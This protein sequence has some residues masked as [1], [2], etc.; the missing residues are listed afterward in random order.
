MRHD[1]ILLHQ[2]QQ[3]FLQL[4]IQ[5]EGRLALEV[6]PLDVVDVG[7]RHAGLAVQV[8]DTA[9]EGLRIVRDGVAGELHDLPANVDDVAALRRAPGGLDV[10][11]QDGALD[12]LAHVGDGVRVAV[13]ADL[14]RDGAGGAALHL[15]DGGAQVRVGEV[16][17]EQRAGEVA[18]AR[19]AHLVAELA[20]A[21]CQVQ[22]HVKLK[23]WF[24]VCA[25]F[26]HQGFQGLLAALALGLHGVVVAVDEHGDK[27]LAVVLERLLCIHICVPFGSL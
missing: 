23:T 17:G 12:G 18:Q 8:G 13:A 10:D 7:Q 4:G 20:V 2:L 21:I 11:A 24:I 25:P 26:V 14:A 1:G 27:R 6:A 3:L 9:V 22:D 19:L 16:A 5:A 15:A